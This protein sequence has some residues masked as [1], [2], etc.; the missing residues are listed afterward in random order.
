MPPYFRNFAAR[1]PMTRMLRDFAEIWFHD[2]EYQSFPGEPVTPHCLVAHELRSGRRM[3]VW[4][5]PGIKPP[6]RMDSDCL[7][8]SFNAA[9]EL[10][11]HLALGWP[12]PV[13]VMDL[14]AE[15]RCLTNGLVLPA[16]RGLLG[17]M[18]HF[19]L[20]SISV[21]EKEEM[22]KLAMRGGPY[23]QQERKDLL[24]YCETDVV[25]LPKLL[26]R[27]WDKIN[28]AQALHRGRYMRALAVMEWN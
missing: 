14:S 27:M 21:A 24:E 19:K 16:G 5:D 25:A 18:A 11:C 17:A 2:F 10:S 3:R 28:L 8:L 13:N 1:N 12:L 23:T 4:C 9:A 7:F 22:R 6:Y 15:F 26:G 20:D